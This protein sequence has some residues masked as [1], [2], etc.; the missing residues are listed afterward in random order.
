MKC[1]VATS[2]GL[3]ADLATIRRASD[4]ALVDPACASVAQPHMIIAVLASTGVEKRECIT[5]PGIFK[6]SGMA[7]SVRA[8]SDIPFD[9]YLL[10]V[11]RRDGQKCR[12]NGSREPE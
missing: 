8:D 9:P 7:V 3:A 4:E 5:R 6:R 12:R 1:T 10:R 11:H 2:D